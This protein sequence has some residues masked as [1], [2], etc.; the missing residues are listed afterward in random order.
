M[1]PIRSFP[2]KHILNTR[3]LRW[4][5][6]A[7]CRQVTSSL[8]PS[9]CAFHFK[10]NIK[11]QGDSLEL[12]VS[13]P[14]VDVSARHPRSQ[15][16]FDPLCAVLFLLFRL[17]FVISSCSS[18]PRFP[19]LRNK[20]TNVLVFSYVF[21]LFFGGVGGKRL[22]WNESSL[23]CSER[24]FSHTVHLTRRLTCLLKPFDHMLDCSSMWQRKPI[25][26]PLYNSRFC[27]GWAV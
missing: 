1:T 3:H 27:L 23:P 19:L 13:R 12:K 21:F 2:V 18:A 7:A 11:K 6:I 22:N 14:G 15:K 10:K 20:C 25:T 24:C 17:M 26:V 5:I 16:P 4:E 9:D 8:G